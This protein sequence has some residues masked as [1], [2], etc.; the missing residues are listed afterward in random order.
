MPG[1]HFA[2]VY[3]S[4]AA[5][6]ETPPPSNWTGAPRAGS[7]AL[8]TSP[9]A[10]STSFTVTLAPHIAGD[11]LFVFIASD[12]VTAVLSCSGWT[13]V[14]ATA[15]TTA[16]GHLFRRDMVAS[17]S[18]EPNPVFTSTVSEQYAAI[19]YSIPGDTLLNIECATAVGSSGTPNAPALTP[20]GGTKDYIWIVFYAFD[21]SAG[22]AT[23]PTGYGGPAGG[24][25]GSG[26]GASALSAFKSSTAST[27]DDP[28][29]AATTSEQFTAF[30]IAV[31]Q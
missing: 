6:P 14:N 17:S 16:K 11:T 4:G 21:G 29:A 18:S 3:L 10:D 20:S 13:L 15:N 22:M 25:N 30:T 28:D 27:S 12:G 1:S 26:S 8:T 2:A 19:S 23:P 31:W 5:Q 24:G 7:P 9:T